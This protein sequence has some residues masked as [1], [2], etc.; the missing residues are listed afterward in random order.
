M[1]K[2]GLNSFTTLSRLLTTPKK[3]ALENIVGKGENVGSQIRP[4]LFDASP[5]SSLGGGGIVV[6]RANK[7][8]M[9]KMAIMILSIH[10]GLC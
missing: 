10:L 5:S 3:T 7:V 8:A 1:A 4:V 6:L 2:R 9:E